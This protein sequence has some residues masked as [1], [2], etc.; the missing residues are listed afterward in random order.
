MTE[1]ELDERELWPE[2]AGVGEIFYPP[3]GAFGPRLQNN[4][5]LVMLHTGEMT[6][7]ID[8][9]RFFSPAGTV[10]LLLPGHQERFAFALD[11]ETHHSWLHATF[12]A[13]PPAWQTRLACLPWSL[14]LSPLMAALTAQGL[15]LSRSFRPTGPAM[16]KALA[17][18]MLWL[19]IGEGESQTMSPLQTRQ[20]PVISE[21]LQFIQA[22]LAESLSLARLAG[23]VGVSPAHLIRL[24]HKYCG[25]TVMAYVWE[26][27]VKLGLDL[28]T[29]SGL[30][31]AVIAGRCGFQ[32]SFHFSRR[33]RQ[34]TG[35][36]P[37][38]VRSR[39][40]KGK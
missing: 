8:G 29:N 11:R 21:T 1:P 2:V 37:L 15:Q 12:P 35:Y 36:S 38:E 6:V 17:A 26:Q 32:N 3:G 33:I 27:R 40:W 34:A 31:V 9:I 19:Y 18:Q 24:F 23:A 5:Q 30:S 28:L 10:C 13:L 16:L 39:F 4:V 7:W 22:H 20:P 25:V 14:P